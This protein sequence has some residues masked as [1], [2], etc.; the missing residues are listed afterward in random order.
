LPRTLPNLTRHQQNALLIR[1]IIEIE[2]DKNLLFK[3]L[4]FDRERF[5]TQY[6]ALQIIDYIAERNAIGEGATREDIV[7]NCADAVLSMAP[8]MTESNV[9][10]VLCK[11]LDRLT[12]TAQKRAKF[13]YHYYDSEQG[14][15]R[16]QTFWLLEYKQAEVH[17]P[18]AYFVT[19]EAMT[20]FASM[21]N[22]DIML[23]Q[24]AQEYMIRNLLEKGRIKDSVDLAQSAKNLSREHAL[25][26][27]QRI[28]LIQRNPRQKGW[29][30]EV[31]PRLEESRDHIKRRFDEEH[32]IVKRIDAIRET[33]AGEENEANLVELRMV[34]NGCKARHQDLY[35]CVIS[36][37]DAFVENQITSLQTIK[38]SLLPEFETQII[39]PIMTRPLKDMVQMSQDAAQ[40]FCAVEPPKV[41]DLFVL[42]EL[43]ENAQ[44]PS[45]KEQ[46]HEEQ[47]EADDVENILLDRFDLNMQ[48]TIRDWLAAKLRADKKLSIAEIIQEIDGQDEVD[49][50][51]VLC[52][53]FQIYSAYSDETIF[54][55]KSDPEGIF[56][57]RLASGD[58]LALRLPEDEGEVIHGNT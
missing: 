33:S 23:Q 42:F 14:V 3:D 30:D 12:N 20:L 25:F 43:L 19:V 38:P 16:D 15:F 32:E 8:T 10:Q 5:D 24:E 36:A 4:E 44:Q 7:D 40:A 34:V 17:E 41:L 9:K 18:F 49:D 35:M 22:V 57:H 58:N 11:I 56:E 53:L 6:L 29:L 45:E 48:K 39:P 26:L 51:N 54:S 52:A 2:S 21:L 27:R 50:R 46:V 47:W 31:R 13:E 55:A 37:L 28:L 1:P